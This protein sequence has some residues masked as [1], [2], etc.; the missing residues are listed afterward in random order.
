[1]PPKANTAS[2]IT[3]TKRT[4]ISTNPLSLPKNTLIETRFLQLPAPKKNHRNGYDVKPQSAWYKPFD[5]SR[6]VKAIHIKLGI[7]KIPLPAFSL[8][9]NLTRSQWEQRTS[10]ARKA[11]Q[12][13]RDYQLDGCNSILERK[14]TVVIAPTKAGKTWLFFLPVIAFP[15]KM[16]IIVTPLRGL[17]QAQCDE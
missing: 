9:A 4:N 14:D 8:V 12:A 11:N 2:N 1:M 7:H 6:K 5:F 3:K 16:S 17:G 13:I 10:H 15:D